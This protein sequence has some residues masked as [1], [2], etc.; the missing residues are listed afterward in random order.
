MDRPSFN[1]P[2]VP[3]LYWRAD[4]LR[5]F[6]TAVADISSF[7][8]SFLLI[9]SEVAAD[10]PC[11]LGN[12]GQYVMKPSEAAS[13]YGDRALLEL[14]PGYYRYEGARCAIFAPR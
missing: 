7:I 10:G 6:D 8:V 14:H 5:P 12:V 9:D 1:V 2:S 13:L 4:D 11:E 3:L